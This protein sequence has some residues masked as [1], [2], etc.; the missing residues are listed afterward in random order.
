MRRLDLVLD[1]LDGLKV[2]DGLHVE[3]RSRVLVDDD[4]C[5]R[6]Q[7]ERRECP[8]VVD[9]LLDRLGE[10]ERLALPGN[11]DNNLARLEHGRD[12]NSERHARHRGDVVVEEARICEDR[13]VRERLD[14]G[15]GR[16]GRAYVCT[17]AGREQS[18]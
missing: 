17:C 15:A 3:L 11:D 7:L 1:A 16:E 14:A 5:P 6:V 12:A 4:E 8:E 18:R 13:V 9:A 2:L 10:R